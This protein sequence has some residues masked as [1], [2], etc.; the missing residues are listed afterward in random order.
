MIHARAGLEGSSPKSLLRLGGEAGDSP[1]TKDGEEGGVAATKSLEMPG[2]TTKA[3]D[4]CKSNESNQ[5]THAKLCQ[6]GFWSEPITANRL[7]R[8]QGIGFVGAWVSW[9]PASSGRSQLC[10]NIARFRWQM[11]TVPIMWPSC[12]HGLKKKGPQLTKFYY[13]HELIFSIGQEF[14]SMPIRF[15]K[16]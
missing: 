10:W 9:Y 4:V 2:V 16:R 1:D 12:G 5:L 6:I 14:Q 3:W 15:F 13:F 8:E 7:R 11:W